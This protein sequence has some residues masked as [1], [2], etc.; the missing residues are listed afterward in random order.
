L[1]FENF[2]G[3][4][5]ILGSSDFGIVKVTSNDN[6]SPGSF[7]VDTFTRPAYFSSKG[8]NARGRLSSC[9]GLLATEGVKSRMGRGSLLPREVF[10]VN[11]FFEF[12]F[13]GGKGVEIGEERVGDLICRDGLSV[14]GEL[15]AERVDVSDGTKSPFAGDEDVISVNDS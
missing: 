9:F 2:E 3:F 1:L 11:V 6:F 12:G 5:N 14:M 10:P 15:A 13:L 8:S 7:A 4:V